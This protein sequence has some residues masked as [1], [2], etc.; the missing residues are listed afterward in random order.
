MGV[1]SRLFVVPNGTDTKFFKPNNG[2]VAENS[3]LWIG[4]MDVHTN[5]D[6]VLYFWKD[7]YPIL[8]RKY[9]QVKMTFVGTAPPKEIADAA[10]KDP[11]VRATGFVDDIRPYIDE[12]AI[13][14]VPIRIGS[15]TR[16][17][18]LDAMAMGKAIV[19]TSVGC[20]GLNVNDEKDILIAD[21]PEDFANKAIDLLKNSNKRIALEKNAIELAKTYDW[22]LITQRQELAYHQVIKAGEV[23]LL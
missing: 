23:N 10:Q 2:E 19:S 4:H 20:E 8:K 15:G 9:P 13:M 16:L 7:I 21:E 6:A 1:K 12:A 5:K 18:I 17:K 11:Q 14:V 22:D 3:V